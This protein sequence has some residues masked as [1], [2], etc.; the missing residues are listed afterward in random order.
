M[1]ATLTTTTLEQLGLVGSSLL[2]AYTIGYVAHLVIAGIF[3]ASIK[4]IL[5]IRQW[6]GWITPAS[7]VLLVGFGV[8]SLVSRF[9]PIA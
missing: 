9:L 1:L 4:K 7:G 5:A 3:T 8:F 2:L 6:S